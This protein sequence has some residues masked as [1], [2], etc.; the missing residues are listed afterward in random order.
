[1]R[2]VGMNKGKPRIWLE[3]SE[4]ISNGITH[5]M[6]FD[7]HPVK[8]GLAIQIN[9]EGKRKIAGTPARP[10]IDMS[11]GTVTTGGFDIGDTFDIVNSASGIGLI[12]RIES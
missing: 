5:G 7:V 11:G 3:G 10:I 6:R 9:P 2:K 1:M 4:L 8:D 12:K